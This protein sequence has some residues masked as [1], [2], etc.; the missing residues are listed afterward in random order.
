MS[1]TTQ[2]QAFLNLPIATALCTARGSRVTVDS[3]NAIAAE[4]FETEDSPE[5]GRLI[6]ELQLDTKRAA[7]KRNIEGLNISASPLSEPI[8]DGP[9]AWVV[10]VTPTPP[11]NVAGNN[12]LADILAELPEANPN[13]VMIVHC[14]DTI[15][16]VNPTGRAWL[17]GRE[18]D[19]Y[20]ELRLLLPEELKSDICA[21][22]SRYPREWS[23]QVE[24]RSYDVKLTSLSGGDRC[25]ITLTDVTEIRRLTREHEIFARALETAK[26]SMLITNATGEIEFVNRHFEELYGYPAKRVIG[27]N[28][29]ILNPGIEAYLELGYNKEQYRNLFEEMWRKITDPAIGYWEGELPNRAA[30]GRLV[31]VRLLVHAVRG[32]N[33]SIDSFLGFPVDISESRSRERQVRLEIYQAITE[34]A[35][36]RDSETGNHIQRVGRYAEQLAQRLKLPRK[37]QEDLLSF[38][39]LHDIGKVG[40]PDHLLLADRKLSP[41]EFRHMQR[42]ATLGY[43]L[44]RNKPTMEM[45]AE[46][47][48]GHHEHWAGGGYPQGIRGEAIPLSARIVSVCDVYDAL[49]STRPYKSS[50]SHDQAVNAIREA[51][52]TQ[53]DPAVVDAFLSCEDCIAQIR[54]ELADE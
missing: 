20:D 34:L 1:R 4:R 25:M 40:I 17:V 8:D 38:A 9:R 47:A 14:P 32:E 24:E 52:G 29:R 49:R 37:F 7:L 27:E 42:H 11:A 19:S 12:R 21:S 48:Y 31:W 28:P 36:L 41:D 39:P 6:D 44:L 43:E 53:F 22:C 10:T 5:L 50:W 18:S 54:V 16:Y 2:E 23:T 26:T 3:L 33:G 30:D 45:A 51:R 46:I 35:E 13:I 15:E